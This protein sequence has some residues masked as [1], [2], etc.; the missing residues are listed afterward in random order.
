MTEAPI[1]MMFTDAD[2][3]SDKPY[4][5][6]TD[7]PNTDYIWNYFACYTPE[8]FYDTWKEIVTEPH[9]MWYWV[10]DNG[11]CICSGAPDPDDI[12]IF[13]M[14][15]KRR[16]RRL[17]SMPQYPIERDELCKIVENTVGY[18]TL[19]DAFCYG[20]FNQGDEF[21]WF[22]NGD[23]FYIVH[24]DSGMLI[25][26]YKHLGRCNTC[27]QSN[28]TADDYYE[29]FRRFKEDLKYW[30]ECHKIKLDR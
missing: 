12:Y 14:H 7:D 13:E 2:D 27:S 29:F 9:G 5:Y 16:F 3:T 17:T 26:W 22:R 10:I 21:A 11:D 19:L 8:E 23:G 6:F 4:K 20:E 28:R 30:A 24:L 25:N 18:E 15:W 1:V